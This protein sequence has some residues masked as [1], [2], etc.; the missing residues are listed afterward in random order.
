MRKNIEMPS[1]I[2]YTTCHNVSAR[3]VLELFRRNQWR[4]WFTFDDTKYML[5]HALLPAVAWHDREA[6]GI[7]VLW[8]DGRFYANMDT[9]VVDKAYRRQGIATALMKMAVAKLDALQPHYSD[10]DV[11]EDWLPTFYAQFG[12][13][14]SDGP[15]LFHRPTSD[16]L[17]NIVQRRRKRLHKRNRAAR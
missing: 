16:R 17:G 7:A 12:F 15:W 6:V 10:H 2:I 11:H 8:G 13:E 9:L 3:A 1:A 5:Q 14:S 4:D